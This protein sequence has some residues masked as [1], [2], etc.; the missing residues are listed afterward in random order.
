MSFRSKPSH[1]TVRA[2][3]KRPRSLLC[4]IRKYEVQTVTFE[5]NK[6]REQTEFCTMSHHLKGGETTKRSVLCELQSVASCRESMSSRKLRNVF[7]VT[8]LQ[9]PLDY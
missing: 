1:M 3:E 6:A 4:R 9:I 2:N 8:V 5:I 7:C